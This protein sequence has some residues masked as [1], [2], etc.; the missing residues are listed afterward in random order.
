M[1]TLEDYFGRVS[2]IEAPSAHV[3]ENAVE[4]L[5]RVSALLADCVLIESAM[6]PVVNSGWRPASYNAT[7][8]NAA[9]RSRHITGEAIDL[10]DPDGD[11]DD[12]LFNNPQILSRHALWP[13]G[14]RRHRARYGLG[15]RARGLALPGLRR[16]EVVVRV[17]RGLMPRPSRYCCV[18]AW[19][20][21]RSRSTTLWRPTR[22]RAPTTTR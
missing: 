21:C 10:A 20:R 2:H 8:A 17:D 12:F 1:L 15:R 3:R 5:D 7:I 14:G 13:R 16:A 18:T 9:P 22:C 19:P 6:N 11:L 4:L